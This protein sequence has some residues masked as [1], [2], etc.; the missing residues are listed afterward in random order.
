MSLKFCVSQGVLRIDF[1]RNCAGWSA[2]SH[3]TGQIESRTWS[4]EGR[5][6]L[7]QLKF[8][9]NPRPKM[10]RLRSRQSILD[11]QFPSEENFEM[12]LPLIPGMINSFSRLGGRCLFRFPIHRRTP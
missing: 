8:R 5:A 12:A 9:K 10:R 6:R 7:P 11:S 4:L 3:C 2:V 1:D